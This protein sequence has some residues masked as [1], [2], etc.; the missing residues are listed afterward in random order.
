MCH[1]PAE[2]SDCLDCISDSISVLTKLKQL[3]LSQVLQICSDTFQINLL[4]SDDVLPELRKLII[5]HK[6]D[7]SALKRVFSE[8]ANKDKKKFF[9][10]MYDERWFETKS[11]DLPRNVIYKAAYEETTRSACDLYES[12]VETTSSSESD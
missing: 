7:I 10:L 9:Y 11:D 12:D 2:G 6:V 3:T 1:R 4:N 8:R 5:N